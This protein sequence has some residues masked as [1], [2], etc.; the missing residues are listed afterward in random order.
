MP[1]KY[2]VFDVYGG[3]GYNRAADDYSQADQKRLDENRNII[4]AAL[5]I[6]I[7][8]ATFILLTIRPNAGSCRIFEKTCCPVGA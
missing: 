1:K 5:G 4:V 2:S 8:F 6:L 7:F 3:G